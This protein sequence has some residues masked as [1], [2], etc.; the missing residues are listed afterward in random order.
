MLN[1]IILKNVSQNRTFY[2]YEQCLF[3]ISAHYFLYNIYIS[4]MKNLPR[5]LHH[6]LLF[7][8]VSGLVF[9]SLIKSL[10]II[11]SILLCSSSLHC[12]LLF[13]LLLNFLLNLSMLNRVTLPSSYWIANSTFIYISVYILITFESCSFSYS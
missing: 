10:Y 5:L 13:M 1:N 6:L 12:Y 8:Y 3:N 9:Y 7:V 2:I 11:K 4:C